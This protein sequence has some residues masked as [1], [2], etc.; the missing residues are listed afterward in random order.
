MIVYLVG[1]TGAGKSTFGEKFA[2]VLEYDFVDLDIYIE[3]KAGKTIAQIFDLQGE[4][5]FRQLEKEALHEVSKLENTLVATGGGT[6]CFFDNM[7]FMNETGHTVF[8]NIHPEIV[9]ERLAKSNNTHRPMLAGKSKDEILQFVRQKLDE[10]I[11]FYEQ[12]T[13]EVL[14]DNLVDFRML[15]SMIF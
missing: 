9:A 2:Q 10:R 6:P 12:A 11:D 3:K 7:D 4:I 14:D 8:L 1:I 13:M 5:G 15:K